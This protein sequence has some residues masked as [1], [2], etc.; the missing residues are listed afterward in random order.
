MGNSID[1]LASSTPSAES[2]QGYGTWFRIAPSE[3]GLARAW[4]PMFIALWLLNLFTVDLRHFANDAG[5]SNLDFYFIMAAVYLLMA[6]L[7]A[8]RSMRKILVIYALA[9]VPS[10]LM[11][12]YWLLRRN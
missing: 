5:L 7:P 3:F 12:W 2:K 8:A 11:I 9:Y 4:N 10:S 6:F 1:A